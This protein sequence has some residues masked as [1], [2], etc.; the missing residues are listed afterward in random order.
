[1]DLVFAFEA[2]VSL[3]Q[4]N[5]LGK[6]PVGH[7]RIIDIVSGTVTG[8]KLEG[9]IL[10]GGADWQ[11][12]RDDD[13]TFLDA[14]YTIKT[15]DDAL[16]YVNNR[17]YRHG[18]KEVIERLKRGESVEDTSYYFRCTPWFETSAPKYSWLNRTIFVAS[19]ARDPEAV[20]LAFY[21]V[22]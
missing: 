11:Y 5:D 2:T 1:M 9:K 7:R 12:V 16:I 3:A 21:E 14:R 10:A 18:P 17:G 6:T 4:I 8:P 19:G 22:T 13:V 20:R 15:F